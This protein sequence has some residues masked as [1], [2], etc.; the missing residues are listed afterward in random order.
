[1]PKSNR[2]PV[3]K[4]YRAVGRLNDAEKGA[5]GQAN[6]SARAAAT[7]NAE[8]RT[9]AEKN[10]WNTAIRDTYKT[11][12]PEEAMRAA[13]RAKK[14]DLGSMAGEVRKAANAKKSGSDKKP[15][16]R[17]AAAIKAAQTRKMRGTSGRK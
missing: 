15:R 6:P 11:L 16:D 5:R 2:D 14:D 8:G 7:Q 4:I 12:S 9:K 3:K 1:M 10:S 17:R 13:G